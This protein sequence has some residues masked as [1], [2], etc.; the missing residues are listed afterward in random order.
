MSRLAKRP[1]ADHKATADRLRQQPG[2]WQPVHEYRSTITADD[3]VYR[4]RTGCRM[5]PNSLNPYQP[6]GAYETRTE[7]TDDGVRVDAR[8]IGS[9]RLRRR[10]LLAAIRAEG[11][12]WSTGRAHALYRALG[13]GPN[14][15]TA[16]LDLHYWTRC[17]VLIEEGPANGRTYRFNHQQ[18]STR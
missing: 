18:G 8:Y 17:G 13:Y 2:V 9:E 10:R 12:V 3:V 16:R 15:R 7:L 4:I 14:R 6:A 1:R 11:G 5:G